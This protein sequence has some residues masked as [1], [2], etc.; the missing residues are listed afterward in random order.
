M[1]KMI[2]FLAVTCPLF[3]NF[4]A[5][6]EKLV[7]KLI[8]IESGG[9]TKAIGDSGR[10]KGCLQIWSCIILEVNSIYKTNYKHND[11]FDKEK[12]KKIC[13]LY[14]K[15]WS[16]VKKVS[17]EK[18]LAFLWNGGPNFKKASSKKKQNLNNYWRKVSAL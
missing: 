2:M 16:K 1:K 12:S 7:P 17:D 8:K 18:S 4:D 15:H 10:A 9:N 5:T 6:F 14:L 11:A 13:Y 3:G